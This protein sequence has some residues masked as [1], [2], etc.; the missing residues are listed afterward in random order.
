MNRTRKTERSGAIAPNGSKV[1]LLKN[2]ILRGSNIY[3]STTVMEQQIDPGNLAG[4]TN[5]S[6]GLQFTDR[7][8]KRFSDMEV[9]SNNCFDKA[10]QHR[11]YRN[12]GVPFEEIILEAILTI[13]SAIAYSMRRTNYLRFGK[14]R[15]NAPQDTAVMIWECMVPRMSREAAALACLGIIELLPERYA[16]AMATTKSES[17]YKTRIAKLLKAARR[18]QQSLD[19]SALAYAAQQRGLPYQIIGNSY[20]AL[21]HGIAQQVIH[22]SCASAAQHSRTG[23]KPAK[24]PDIDAVDDVALFSDSAANVDNIPQSQDQDSSTVPAL[25][26]LLVVESKLRGALTISAPA[27]IG[28]GQ[29]TIGELIS[30]RNRQTYRLGIGH[31]P[32]SIDR[33]LDDYL[34]ARNQ[35]T[36][37]VLAKDKC[38]PL[39]YITAINAGACHADITDAVHPDYEKA[40]LSAMRRRNLRTAAVDIVTANIASSPDSHRVHIV[41]TNSNPALWPYVWPQQGMSRNVGEHVLEAVYPA[42]CNGRVPILLIAGQHGTHRIA[43]AAEHMHRNA[44]RNTALALKTK[45]FLN[46]KAIKHDSSMRSN[47][48]RDLLRNYETEIMI[49][50]MSFRDIVRRGLGL[51]HTDVT[52]ILDSEPG[53]D[54]DEYRL[55]VEVLL[56]STT[57][58]YIVS[59]RNTVALELLAETPR[60]QIILVSHDLRNPQLELQRQQDC[61][62]LIE[63]KQH[64]QKFIA[65]LKGSVIVAS[66][67]VESVPAS[68]TEAAA[69]SIDHMFSLALAYASGLPIEDIPN[70]N[71]DRISTRL[72][73]AQKIM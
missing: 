31:F 52:A 14:L 28:D 25:H 61:L 67:V 65:I 9:M 55:A 27:L 2:S 19:T 13:E 60:H 16:V 35:T 40:A 64:E 41:R 24:L 44:G 48:M 73:S 5:Q 15:Q 23:S 33:A 68:D 8:I 26:R 45:S 66:E 22:A 4:L 17:G 6:I 72:N 37:S 18:R 7:L 11:L 43:R 36:L 53:Q 63:V 59:S 32:I 70:T 51:N 62:S 50:T 56:K 3:H 47:A 10:F 1:R 58:I 30:L 21:G 49:G 20:L 71:T 29:S 38:L 57:S 42:T 54:T 12:D 69:L 39:S 34:D 46:G